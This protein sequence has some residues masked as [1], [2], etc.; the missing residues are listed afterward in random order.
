MKHVLT[1]LLAL[2]TSHAFAGYTASDN[3][4]MSLL[5]MFKPEISSAEIRSK[6]MFDLG[7]GVRVVEHFEY[8]NIW[9]LE[10]EPEKISQQ[11]ALTLLRNDPQILN[12]SPVRN[13]VTM[14]SAFPTDEFF[15][16]QWSLHNTGQTGGTPGADIKAL[17]AWDITRG[18]SWGTHVP[19][20]AVVDDGFQQ[21]HPDL[22]FLSGGYN[23]YDDNFNVPVTAHGT[24]VSGILG[25]KA[26]NTVGIAG[27]NWDTDIFPVAGSSPSEVVVVRAYNHILGLRQQYN[28]SGGSNGRYIVATNS[29]FGVNFGDPED[30]PYWCAM[31]DANGCSRHHQYCSNS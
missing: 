12:A 22:G 6:S 11:E 21:N 3:S 18:D 16:D 23:A 24:R 30:Y 29:S 13:S 28:S 10:Y 2:F 31:Y 17:Y 26:N 9:H 5:V 1:L 27:V 4:S 15:S 19:V 14:R 20:I 7:A 25:A 8:V